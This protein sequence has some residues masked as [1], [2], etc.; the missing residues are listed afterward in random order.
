M[1][2]DTC[3]DSEYSYSIN[4]LESNYGLW[5]MVKEDLLQYQSKSRID[6]KFREDELIEEF[7]QYID[8]TY[9]GH[10][11]SGNLQSSEVI[12]DRGNGMGFFSGNVDKYNARYGKKG[13][14][15]TEYRKDIV[16]IIHYGFLMLYEHDR[17]HGYNSQ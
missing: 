6:Y 7:K 10:Y 17:I 16:K 12:V 4:S 1:T 8:K 3:N 15:P 14:S 13:E 5:S 2:K 11:N 9:S